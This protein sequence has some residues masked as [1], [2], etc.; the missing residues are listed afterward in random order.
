MR[1]R[2]CGAKEGQD[3]ETEPK[4]APGVGDENPRSEDQKTE[5]TGLTRVAI[6]YRG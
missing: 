5:E 4:G 6:G 2:L 3:R 1:M